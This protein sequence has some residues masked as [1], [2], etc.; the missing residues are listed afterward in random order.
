MTVPARCL[1]S[2]TARGM[3]YRRRGAG[4]SV[5][6]LHDRCLDGQMWMYSEEL[7]ADRYDIIVPDLPG[8][9]A[10][11]HLA[12]PYP[13]DRYAADVRQLTEELGLGPAVLV[14]FGFGAAVAM[15]AAARCPRKTRAVVAVAV[16][17]A[18][19][20]A[21]A[22]QPAEMRSDW[23]DF[24]RRS[25]DGLMRNCRSTATLDWLERIFVSTP[26]PV[27][28]ETARVLS[29]FDPAPL[30][31]ELHMPTLFIH[32]A[33]DDL[34]PAAV[35]EACRAAAPEARLTVL[36][37]SGHLIP[38]DAKAAFHARLDAFLAEVTGRPPHELEA[39]LGFSTQAVAAAVQPA[40]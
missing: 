32:G 10:S 23:P 3:A 4:P 11:S 2:A 37:E 13:L 1:R 24:A 20:V 33:R 6:L 9:G 38:L 21:Y 5:V 39:P 27:A 18:A 35:G 36:E 31:A 30:A 26:L 29:V 14:G 40:L 15:A 28:V 7:L 19:A 17:D 16:P 34:A 12:G 25:V 22:D 8:F